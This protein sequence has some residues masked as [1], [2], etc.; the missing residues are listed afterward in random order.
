MPLFRGRTIMDFFIPQSLN[1]ESQFN[2]NL[3]NLDEIKLLDIL[4]DFSLN[5]AQLR[6]LVVLDALKYKPRT[7]HGVAIKTGLSI[8]EVL[9]IVKA[10]LSNGFINNR[11]VL[12]SLAY[13]EFRYLQRST[14]KVV[15]EYVYNDSDYY[16]MMLR[17]PEIAFSSNYPL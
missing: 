9:R 8:S 12:T 14:R 17:P 1:Q 6:F 5:E 15:Q 13:E 10:A 4:S 7:I 16:P 2:Y 3:T 11:L